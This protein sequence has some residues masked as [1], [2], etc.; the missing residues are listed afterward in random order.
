MILWGGH[1]SDMRLNYS[2]LYF[3]ILYL[4]I[5]GANSSLCMP[6]VLHKESPGAADAPPPI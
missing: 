2:R 3:S 6:A 5:A 4:D 1:R